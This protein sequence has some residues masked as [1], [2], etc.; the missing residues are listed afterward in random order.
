MKRVLRSGGQFVMACPYFPRRY[1]G[2]ITRRELM[3][4]MQEAGFRE[5][6]FRATGLSGAVIGWKKGKV[7]E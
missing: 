4:H 1:E 6:S 5:V 2:E 7:D 3:R